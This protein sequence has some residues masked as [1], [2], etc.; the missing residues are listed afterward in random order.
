[1]ALLEVRRMGEQLRLYESRLRYIWELSASVKHTS[2]SYLHCDDSE[3]SF[4]IAKVPGKDDD[5]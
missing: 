3:D 4:L 1:M 5:E 2:M